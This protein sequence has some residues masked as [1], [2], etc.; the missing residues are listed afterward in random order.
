MALDFV[1][2]S[3]RVDHVS[4]VSQ[5]AI[6]ALGRQVHRSARRRRS[7][8]TG[9]SATANSCTAATTSQFDH[10]VGAVRGIRLARRI[11]SIAFIDMMRC[12]ISRAAI[13]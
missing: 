13:R 12:A 2:L 1:F 3:L 5:A 6:E 7:I 9:L 10:L 8:K 4:R 11:R